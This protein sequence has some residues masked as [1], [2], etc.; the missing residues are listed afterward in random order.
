MK[1][2]AGMPCNG[3][4]H[5]S[6]ISDIV[7]LQISAECNEGSLVTHLV[8]RKIKDRCMTYWFSISNQ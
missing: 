3:M 4:A 5:H 2:D 1:C 6:I 7:K 8:T